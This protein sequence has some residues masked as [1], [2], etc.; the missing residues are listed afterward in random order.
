MSDRA[1]QWVAILGGASRYDEGQLRAAYRCGLELARQG[2]NV[3]TGAT[4]G[5]PYAA[6]LGARD[7]GGMVVGI[8]PATSAKEHVERYGRPLSA[9]DLV[10]YSGHNV[11]GRGPLI[12]RSA[13]AA[14][15]IGG[16]MGTLA[17]FAIGWICGCPYLGLLESAGGITADLRRIAGAMHTNFGS[18][19]I[20]S[21]D[22]ADLVAK[23]CRCL[24]S[25]NVQSPAECAGAADVVAMLAEVRA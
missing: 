17:E 10:I 21:D 18:S 2:R 11:D 13:G 25:S 3:L 14:I 9:L 22:P 4:T 15:F 23:I 6:A 8:S 24:D 1:S 5:V 12:L 16:E 20:V 7:R 19:L